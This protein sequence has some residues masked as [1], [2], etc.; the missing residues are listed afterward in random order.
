MNLAP[1]LCPRSIAVIGASDNKA[2]IGGVPVDLLIRSGFKKLYPV[3]PK[4]ATVQGLNAFADIESVPELVDLAIIALSAELTLPMLERCHALGIPAA[5]VYASGYAETN[6]AEGQARQD[7]LAATII[8]LKGAT[9][10]LQIPVGR[11]R[12]GQLGELVNHPGVYV[13][14]TEVFGELCL[15]KLAQSEAAQYFVVG[16]QLRF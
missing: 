13:I 9:L 12:V 14:V 10:S 2:R 7:E 5:L 4:N 1:L 6:E 11:V 3:N 8:D 15:A 16:A